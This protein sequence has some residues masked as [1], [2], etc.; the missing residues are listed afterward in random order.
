MTKWTKREIQELKI[1]VFGG[2]HSHVG[3]CVDPESLDRRDRLMA[4]SEAA[5]QCAL[6]W[7]HEIHNIRR[8]Y[9]FSHETFVQFLDTP[10]GKAV[11]PTSGEDLKERFRKLAVEETKKA[12]WFE[13]LFDKL[14]EAEAL[15][16]GVLS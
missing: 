15:P 8:G 6:S 13:A 11:Y 9:A 5:W 2:A 1:A 12:D 10:Q 16:E 7:L 3:G 14:Y 4:D